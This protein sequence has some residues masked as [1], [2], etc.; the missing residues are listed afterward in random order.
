MTNSTISIKAQGLLNPIGRFLVKLTFLCTLVSFLFPVYSYA[1]NQ[2]DPTAQKLRQQLHED[3]FELRRLEFSDTSTNAKHIFGSQISGPVLSKYI[4]D[5]VFNFRYRYDANLHL[6][7]S[8]QN[9]TITIHNGY[10]TL[11]FIKRVAALIH[12]SRHAANSQDDEPHV[13]CPSP[14][15]VQ[16]EFQQYQLKLGNLNDF[17]KIPACDNNERGAYGVQASFLA[18][19]VRFC[20]NC[21]QETRQTAWETYVTDGI[22]RITNPSAASRSIHGDLG[23]DEIRILKER[24]KRYAVTSQER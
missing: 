1:Q 7:A 15:I 20:T 16:L 10:L 24:L 8:G 17:K 2:A 13:F 23:R 11:P 14:Y 3:L 12:E 19:L 5:R 21:T 9:H 22:L 6:I 18:N 4:T